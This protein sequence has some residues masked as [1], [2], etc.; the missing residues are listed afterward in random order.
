MHISMH[1]HACLC[2]CVFVCLYVCV[3][4]Y[5]YGIFIGVKNTNST[6]IQCNQCYMQ[7]RLSMVPEQVK[8]LPMPKSNI[9]TGT[10]VT[11]HNISAPRICG[12][13]FATSGRC[14]VFEDTPKS[15]QLAETH[16]QQNLSFPG[17]LG[18]VKD[19]V[20]QSLLET[21]VQK[22]GWGNTWISG[23]VSD[24][25]W[26][27]FSC[28]YIKSYSSRKEPIYCKDWGIK[29]KLGHMTPIE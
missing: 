12:A 14:F 26:S 11:Y 22:K 27:W 1:V 6:G 20:T 5:Y 3:C 16:C 29:I 4:V 2:E 13:D 19:Q 15:W 25:R 21:E 28:E 7:E 17:H 23:K 10:K 8:I 24:R 18:F 9:N